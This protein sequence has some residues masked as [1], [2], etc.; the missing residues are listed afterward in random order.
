MFFNSKNIGAMAYWFRHFDSS[1]SE[2]TLQSLIKVAVLISRRRELENTVK[3]IQTG[4][5]QK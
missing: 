3:L 5:L 4:G 2:S 1:N